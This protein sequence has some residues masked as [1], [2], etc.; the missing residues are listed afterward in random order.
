MEPAETKPSNQTHPLP[1]RERLHEIVFE[2]DTPAGKLFDV[3]LLVAIVLSVVAV[4]FF[5][6]FILRADELLRKIQ[7]EAL[8]IGF[9]GGFVA[10]FALDLAEKVGFESFDISAPLMAMVVCWVVG[11]L[12]AT[13]RYA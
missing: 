8:A 9:G 10:T 6:R 3:V 7:L 1:W 2:A 5:I 13:R 12:V 11:F 4:G